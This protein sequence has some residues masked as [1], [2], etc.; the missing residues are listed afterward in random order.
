MPMRPAAK[1]S[2]GGAVADPFCE[3]FGPVLESS[4]LRLLTHAASVRYSGLFGPPRRRLPAVAVGH[5]RGR[6]ELAS[7]QVVPVHQPERGVQVRP[8]Q[9]VILEVASRPGLH[10]LEFPLEL[11]V[12]ALGALFLQDR[13]DRAAEFLVTLHRE[14]VGQVK[15]DRDTVALRI[16][17]VLVADVAQIQRSRGRNVHLGAGSLYIRILGGKRRNRVPERHHQRPCPAIFGIHRQD[18]INLRL[19]LGHHLLFVAPLGELDS[20]VGVVLGEDREFVAVGLFH[21]VERTHDFATFLEDH[22]DP[23]TDH[24]PL[25]GLL[26]LALQDRAVG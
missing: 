12:V 18:G 1:F 6:Q 14:R 25:V 10:E 21:G 16:A 19:G 24:V 17:G 8:H 13:M 15:D 22:A 2:P 9:Q 26:D 4:V 3:S 23:V 11:L 7:G 5:A 20:L